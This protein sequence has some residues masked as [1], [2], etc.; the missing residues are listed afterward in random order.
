MQAAAIMSKPVVGI[1]PSA[2]IAEAAGLMLFKKISGFPVIRDDGTLVGIVSEGDFLRR[3]ELGTQRKRSRWLEFLV[4]PGKAADE[5]AH[6][7]GRRIEEVMSQ[8]VVTAPPTASLAEVVELMTRHHVKRVPVVD[9]GKVVGIITR[10]D[11][12]RALLNV[13]PDATPSAIDDEE[14][15]QNITTELATKKWAGKDLI[16]VTVKNGVVKLSGA[17]FDERERQAAIVAAENVSGVK[18]VEDGLFC[19]DPVSVLLVS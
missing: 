3:G 1:D 4:S 9:A 14:I 12:L 16:N 2:S 11:L 5:Y 13:L 8:D 17:I 19:A 18:A 10:S 7:N 6:A 15:R